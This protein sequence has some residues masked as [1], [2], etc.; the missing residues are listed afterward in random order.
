MFTELLFQLYENKII[1]I[2][3]NIIYIYI[4]YIIIYILQKF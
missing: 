2:Q 4:Y 3:N 1:T